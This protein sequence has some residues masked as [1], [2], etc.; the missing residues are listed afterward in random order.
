M[1]KEKPIS[2]DLDIPKKSQKKKSSKHLHTSTNWTLVFH[3]SNNFE[4]EK[5]TY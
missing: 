1:P 2:N 4:N 5:K 3:I